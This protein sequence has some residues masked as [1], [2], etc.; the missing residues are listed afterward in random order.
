[1]LILTEENKSYNLDRIPD[2]VEDIRYCVLDCSN[3]ADMDFYWLPLIFLESFNAP[4]VVLDIGPYQLQMPL[5][6]SILVCD[7]SYS[8]M[9]VMP[10]TQ[11]NDRGFH[12][13]TFNPLEH[14]V[15]VSYEVNISNIYADV[16]WFFPK[17]K[18]GNVL[19]MPLAKGVT[20][21]CS[22]FVK[23]GNKVP[24]PLDMAILFDG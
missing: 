18:N 7:D 16:K 1:M 22:L 8:D 9:E 3:A 21:A 6:W 15:P 5:D 11:L 20:P 19:T 23:E 17:L 12:A 14:M 24:D 10:L 13:I 4:A 2:E